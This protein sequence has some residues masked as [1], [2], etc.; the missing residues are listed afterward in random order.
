MKWYR[1][2]LSAI[3]L[4]FGI[5]F[6]TGCSN[7]WMTNTKRSAI[8]QYLMSSTIERVVDQLDFRKYKGKKVFMSYEYL[9]MQDDKAYFQG[10]LEMHLVQSGM[11]I[12][13]KKEEAEMVIEP[14]CGV[15]ATDHDKMLV[16]TPSLPIPLPQTD[17]NLVIPE[18]AL[19]Q[20]ITR[21]ALG[22]FSFNIY[23]SADHTYLAAL[24][25]IKASAFFH[26]WT[27]M[28][29]PFRS[30]NMHMKDTKE[31]NSKYEMF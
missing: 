7:P 27:V 4:A 11:I 23:K 30:H 15:F 21:V 2:S 6:L 22:S 31:T 19:F 14:L 10:Y 20:K 29:V 13:R 3:L 8:E 26:N 28:F 12:V 1:L 5:M 9:T 16:G 25:G 17:I 24:R 18:I